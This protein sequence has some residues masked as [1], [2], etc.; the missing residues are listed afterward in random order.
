MDYGT[1]AI[2]GV[3]RTTSAT[4]SSR[5]NTAA[6]PPRGRAS[7]RGGRADRGEAENGDGVIVNSR[8]STA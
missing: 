7:P 6:D 8:F 4:S 1:G 5:P 3:R 2:F